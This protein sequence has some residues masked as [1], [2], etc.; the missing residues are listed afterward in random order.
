VLSAKQAERVHR[1][2]FG[3]EDLTV[4]AILDGALIDGLPARLRQSGLP[5]ACL[6]AG[7]LDP[8]L[9]AVVPYLVQLTA[10]HALSREAIET[11]WM[12]HWGVYMMTPQSFGVREARNHFRTLLRVRGP[13]GEEWLFRYY[14]PRV[15]RASLPLL[16][17]GQR[18]EFFGPVQ[19]CVLESETADVVLRFDAVS[20]QDQQIALS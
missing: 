9:A 7:Q 5:H 11:G 14:D 3:S 12:A 8:Q 17:P 20:A 16:E 2:I 19:R 15:L 6:Y 1:L 4:Y 13:Q 18:T 10:A